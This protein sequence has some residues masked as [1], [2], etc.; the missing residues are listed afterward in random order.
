M[1]GSLAGFRWFGLLPWFGCFG[2]FGRLGGWLMLAWSDCSGFL[3]GWLHFVSLFGWPAHFGWFGWLVA[4]LGLVG[5][6]GLVCLA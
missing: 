3:A 1:A 6:A 2:W 5:L 4:W